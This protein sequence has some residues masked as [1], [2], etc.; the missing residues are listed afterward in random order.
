V[1]KH[2]TS[3]AKKL[4]KTNH[5]QTP[6]PPQRKL[7]VLKSHSSTKN[8]EQGMTVNSNC[9]KPNQNYKNLTVNTSSAGGGL[10]EQNFSANQL[11]KG[12]RA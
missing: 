8:Q 7:Q 11:G 1:K 3:A 12:C 10:G 4:N 5:K 6:L 9:L 2:S